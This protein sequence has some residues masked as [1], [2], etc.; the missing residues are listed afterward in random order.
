MK[1]LVLSLILLCSISASSQIERVEPPNW[2]IGFKE[3]KLQLLVKGTSISAF[4]PEIEY[5]GVSNTGL[6]S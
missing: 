4:S 6:I 5:A 1:N 3:T 2:W